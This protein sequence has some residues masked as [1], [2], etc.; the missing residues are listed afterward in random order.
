MSGLPPDDNQDPIPPSIDENQ[1]LSW[2]EGLDDVPSFLKGTSMDDPFLGNSPFSAQPNSGSSSPRNYAG[3]GPANP[4]FVDEVTDRLIDE[5][6]RTENEILQ[7]FSRQRD[8]E[9]L[10]QYFDSMEAANADVVDNQEETQGTLE[11]I[12]Q[13]VQ[14]INIEPPQEQQPEPEQGQ[15]QEQ[16]QPIQELLNTLRQDLGRFASSLSATVS[17][18]SGASSPMGA[19]SAAGTA[20]SQALPG[21]GRVAGSAVGN[22]LGG[23]GG[24]VLGALGGGPGIAAGATMGGLAGGVIGGGIGSVL[25]TGINA[26]VDLLVSIDAGI[27]QLADETAGFSPEVTAATVEQDL[28]LLQDSMRRSEDIG[29][30]IAN[31][32]REQTQ[33]QLYSRVAFDAIFSTFAPLLEKIYSGANYLA[34]LLLK[35]IADILETIGQI[36]LLA[37]LGD[38]GREMN[39]NLKK[40]KDNTNKDDDSLG[41][42]FADIIGGGLNAPGGGRPNGNMNRINNQLL[43]IP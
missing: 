36:P 14:D 20:V 10:R 25:S 27:T 28:A 22:V 35:G 23:A 38:I 37:G 16:G 11:A 4:V 2:L 41:D 9:F 19:V 26:M 21:V 17:S 32:V 12:L 42:M 15:G 34:D 5:L 3:D 39:E 8:D 7:E 33:F 18:P 1:I 30:E 40:I 24:A 13:E 6:N 43:G 31:L 29:P